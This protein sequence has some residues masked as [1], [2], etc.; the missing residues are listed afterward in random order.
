LLVSLVGSWLCP[1]PSGGSIGKDA[2]GDRAD[3]MP[4]LRGEGEKAG[5]TLGRVRLMTLENEP[6][7]VSL[8]RNDA[9]RVFD[10]GGLEVWAYVIAYGDIPVGVTIAPQES[11][12][13]VIQT[14]NSQDYEFIGANGGNVSGDGNNLV[15][16]MDA[17][18]SAERVVGLNVCEMIEYV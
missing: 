9:C 3:A 6:L 15:A 8:A 13:V 2:S 1:L 12:L 18:D 7:A 16:A 14:L 4:R 10:G 5:R 11:Y 17:Q